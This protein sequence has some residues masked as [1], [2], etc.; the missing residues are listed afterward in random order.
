MPAYQDIVDDL[1]STAQNIYGSD[2]YLG[3]DSQDYQ[4]ISAVAK[5]I[6]D[7]FL[8]AQISYNA[9]GPSTAIGAGL[10]VQVG[11]NG[12]IRKSPTYS[13]APVTLAGTPNQIITGGVAQDVNGNYWSIQSPVTIGAGGSVTTTATCQ[14]AGPITAN[15]GDINTIATPTLGWT[16]VTNTAAATVGT[17]AE[18]DGQ[19]RARQASSTAQ[20]SQTLLEALQG[21][22][23]A[24][25]GVTRFRVYQNT[26]SSTDSNGVPAHSIAC[27]VEGGTAAD[28]ANAIW[29]YKGPGT[30]T[31]GTTTQDVTD[32]YGVVTPINYDV[33]GYTQI[34][35]VY[36]VK[37]LTGYTADTAT[38]IENAG[39]SFLNGLG[40]G[41]TVYIGSLWSAALSAITDP[42]N[43]TF[44]ITQVQAAVHLGATLTTALT[45]GTAYTA[46][47]VTALTQS[48][49]SGTNLIVGSGSTTQTVTTSAT[50]NV[51]DTTISVTSFTANAAYATGTL[52]SLTPGTTDIPIAF[53]NAA[54][55]VAANITVNAS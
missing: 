13:T 8:T 41:N 14:T 15:P 29:T 54:Q 49:P 19:L 26:T 51:G 39:V 3:T 44:S 31:Y 36:T 9:Q 32:S 10:D 7:S 46:I 23:A 22:L 48:I 34:D 53:N 17:A 21:A 20:P 27:V 33:V 55:G 37:E 43:P 1:V 42:K 4:Y 47:D 52:V 5:K 11:L 35:V 28:I 24:L 38:A 12:L 50:A 16:S 30:G 40:I 45:S 2:I 6:Y 25:S 18:T